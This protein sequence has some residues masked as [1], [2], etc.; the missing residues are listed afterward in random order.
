MAKIDRLLDLMPKLQA[1]DLH[2]M[3]GSPPIFRIHG[4]LQAQGDKPITEE[5][6][7]A[8]IQEIIPKRL[9]KTYAQTK[10]IDF[11]YSVGG[12]RYRVNVFEERRGIAAAFRLIP[13]KIKSIAALGL[14]KSV[15]KLARLKKGMVL[16]TGVTGS[17]KSTTLAS[18]ID[19]INTN[20]G[21]HIITIEDPIEFVHQNKK[22]LI[23]QREV[24]SH[25]QSFASALRAS[26]REDPDII[27]VGE[28]RDLETIELAI[29]AAETGHL[30]FGTLHTSSA[31]KTID[32]IIDV[33]PAY[34][35]SQIRTMLAESLKGVISQN[36][37]PTVNGDGRVA[38]VEVMFNNPAVAS[39][40]RE[41][42]TYQIPT[43]IQTGKKEGMQTMDMALLDLV[44]RGKI[45]GELAY[46]YAVEKKLF[47]EYATFEEAF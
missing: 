46:I 45:Q 11:A 29:T 28:L 39:L 22:S 20:R 23:A 26:L 43:A 34:Q 2:L 16:V 30:V 47:Q 38:A 33:F 25:T 44:N 4:K 14:P 3:V 36:L 17:G 1:S 9:Q 13:S 21:E 41:G 37:L 27:M 18:L 8:L 35:Q 42:K 19:F 12:Y 40:I 24:G 10:D 6:G 5:I 15:V 7:H 32:R 31:A